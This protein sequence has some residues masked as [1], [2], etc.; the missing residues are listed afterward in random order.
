MPPKKRG[1]ATPSSKLRRGAAADASAH[2]LLATRTLHALALVLRRAG[3][4]VQQIESAAAA[5]VSAAT[6]APAKPVAIPITKDSALLGS[7]LTLW[8]RDPNYVDRDGMP[9]PVALYGPKPSVQSLLRAAG[10]KNQSRRAASFLKSAGLLIPAGRGKYVPL[11]RAARMPGINAHFVE[12]IALGVMKLMQTVQHNF[13]PEGKHTALLQRAAAVRHL[14]RRH[15]VAFRDFVNEQGN[16]FITNV[17]DW[18]EARAARHP[19]HSSTAEQA[20]VYAFA[21]LG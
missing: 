9:K 20:G 16:A 21:Y 14:P 12:H 10:L 13:T 15:H 7:A 6:V 4:T 2:L 8:H 18:L 5:A 11:G 17:D 19:T 3:L 1:K